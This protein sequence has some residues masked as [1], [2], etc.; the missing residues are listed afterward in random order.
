MR[1]TEGS[2]RKKERGEIEGEQV[3]APHHILLSGMGEGRKV[4]APQGR[5]VRNADCPREVVAMPTS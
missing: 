4:R 2:Q 1:S 5:V 3:V